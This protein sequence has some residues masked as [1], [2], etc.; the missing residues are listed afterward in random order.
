MAERQLRIDVGDVYAE[1]N[2][3]TA[4]LE[5]Q[6]FMFAALNAQRESGGGSLPANDQIAR[7]HMR[8]ADIRVFRRLKAEALKK[9]LIVEDGDGRLRVRRFE[10]LIT[11][12]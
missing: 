7:V 2:I 6:G 12:G 5:L 1:L 10:F 4:P 8:I 9:R 3:D 11:R